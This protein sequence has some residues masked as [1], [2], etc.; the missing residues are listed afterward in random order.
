M[1]RLKKAGLPPDPTFPTDLNDL[2]FTITSDGLVRHLSDPKKEYSFRVS[3]SD[4]YNERRKEAINDC[5]R[6]YVIDQL[7]HYGVCPLRLPHG[8]LPLRREL[9][10]LRDDGSYYWP[11]EPHVSILATDHAHMHRCTKVVVIINDSVQDLGIWAWRVATGHDGLYKGSAMGVV[12]ELLPEGDRTGSSPFVA[13]DEADPGI[14]I[15]NPGQLCYS[16]SLDTSMSI[17][18]WK[19]RTMDSESGLPLTIDETWNKVEGH[20]LPEDHIK[21]V[22]KDVVEEYVN[23]DAQL[24]VVGIGRGGDHFVEMLREQFRREPLLSS[25]CSENAGPRKTTYITALALMYPTVQYSPHDPAPLRTLL[26]ERTRSWV[27]SS[28]S[29]NSLVEAPIA[30]IVP[31]QRD[32]IDGIDKYIDQLSISQSV[33]ADGESV[34]CP[35]YSSGQEAFVEMIFPAVYKEVLQW[36]EAVEQ[37]QTLDGEDGPEFVDYAGVKLQKSLVEQAGLL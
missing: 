35:T 26:H 9:L 14:I 37:I 2:D 29:K 19:T 17:T 10:A 3:D 25:A 7:C 23:K 13:N 1:F 11:P 33:E 15:M 6:E 4:R 5:V 22:W 21:T 16:P 32:Y 34:L 20:R 30:P 27:L 8:L 28:E 18:R 31:S 36:F 24:F 12:K